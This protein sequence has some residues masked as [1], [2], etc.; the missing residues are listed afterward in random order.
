[1]IAF[2]DVVKKGENFS[3]VDISNACD[4]AAEDALMTLKLFNKQLEVFKEKN[5]FFSY[6][7]FIVSCRD[8]GI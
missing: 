7:S 2:K 5:Y 8:W 6:W 3:N 4:Y 1:M